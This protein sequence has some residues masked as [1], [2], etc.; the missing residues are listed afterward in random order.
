M[1]KTYEQL[2]QTKDLAA[3]VVKSQHLEANPEFLPPGAQIPVS[4]DDATGMLAG[5]THIQIRLGTRLID[6]SVEHPSN[7]MAA[8]LANELAKE[9]VNQ[10]IDQHQG[11]GNLLADQLQKQVDQLQQQ[12]ST[13]TS[14]MKSYAASHNILVQTLDPRTATT[15]P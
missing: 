6:I 15:P 10:Y 2:L 11:S 4:T 9:S 3:R 5:R 14:A 1:I 7:R 12:L 8:L 13:A